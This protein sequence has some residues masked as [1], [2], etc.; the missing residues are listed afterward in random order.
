MRSTTSNPRSRPM[1]MLVACAV[2]ALCAGV[3]LAQPAATPPASPATQTA[4]Q[5]KKAP[6]TEL[7]LR[8]GVPVQPGDVV[9][10]SDQG[11]R[12]A[13]G[14]RSTWLSWDQVRSVPQAFAA[15]AQAHMQTADLAWRARTRLARADIA[16]A[17]PL[18]EQ[19]FAKTVGTRGKTSAMVAAGLLRCRLHRQAQVASVEAWLALVASGEN[20]PLFMPLREDRTGAARSIL[21]KPLLDRETLLC[22]DLPPLWVPGVGL[23]T[24]A[25]RPEPAQAAGA[26]S[27]DAGFA[28]DRRAVVART[29]VELYA[30]SARIAMGENVTL[31]ARPASDAGPEFAGARLVWDIIAVQAGTPE[32]RS[33]ARVHLQSILDQIDED[34]AAFPGWI[35]AWAR[36]GLA[37]SYLASTNPEEKAQGI[38]IAL[39]VPALLADDSPFLAG[40][41]LADVGLVR[42]AQGNLASAKVLRDE[43][44]RIAPTHPALAGLEATIAAS[45]E[46]AMNAS[47]AQPTAPPPGEASPPP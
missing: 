25:M 18:F 42:V 44:R 7:V 47:A 6:A 45:A 33:A 14:S 1:P 31:P 34:E 4:P 3:A 13:D 29:L 32:Q 12:I 8:A 36:T 37:R 22:P 21:D 27:T 40:L 5:T 10:V 38:A 17:E 16:G 15:E 35:E 20:P 41:C 24:I 2:V 43:L 23:R 11:V 39:G 28:S 46:A 30:L 9:E 19:L 26:T